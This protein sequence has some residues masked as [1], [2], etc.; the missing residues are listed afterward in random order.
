VKFLAE[1]RSL[2]RLK[3]S[4]FFAAQCE[5]F[6]VQFSVNAKTRA[7]GRNSV[8]RS[9]GSSAFRR[10]SAPFSPVQ[11]PE[12][13]SRHHLFCLSGIACF[14]RLSQPVSVTPER[15]SGAGSHPVHLEMGVTAH[16][17]TA[18]PLPM[19]IPS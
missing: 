16:A 1:Y 17:G 9:V 6:S 7:G 3:F 19:L 18:T 13:V 4:V 11:F 15:I 10:S 12:A 2:R 5:V 8:K 14:R